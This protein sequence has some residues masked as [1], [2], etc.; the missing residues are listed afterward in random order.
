MQRLHI[1]PTST[2]PE[3]ILSPEDNCFIIRGKSAPEDVRSLYYPVIEWMKIFIDDVLKGEYKSFNAGNPVRFQIDLSYFNSSSAKFLYD[4]LQELK[5]LNSA[6]IPVV[7]DWIY[8]EGDTDM[9]EAGS[10]I[11]ALAGLDFSFILKPR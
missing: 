9:K 11:S 5:R 1:K 4:I 8:E 3:I 2:S 6:G 7:V 10:D